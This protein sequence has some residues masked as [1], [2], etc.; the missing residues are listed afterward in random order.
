MFGPSGPMSTPCTTPHE[1]KP[2]SHEGCPTSP[3][4][5]STPLARQINNDD[6]NLS[7]GFRSLVGSPSTDMRAVRLNS[8]GVRPL[9]TKA[10]LFRSPPP[11]LTSERV[12]QHDRDLW[13]Q[14]QTES[15]SLLRNIPLFRELSS[16]S[17]GFAPF[18]FIDDMPITTVA[19]STE[20]PALD[21]NDNDSLSNQFSTQ[22]M[23]SLQSLE[24]SL[25]SQGSNSRRGAV[26]TPPS[27]PGAFEAQ[28]MLVHCPAPKAKR[29]RAEARPSALRSRFSPMFSPPDF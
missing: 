6:D 10:S 20:Q 25:S 16:S 26:D 15:P 11:A 24:G 21:A 2:R 27:A 29:M 18:S 28:N 9:S 1:P 5:T 13:A 14:R 23:S 17:V 3:L 19:V 4:L 22:S 12:A 7:I 8:P